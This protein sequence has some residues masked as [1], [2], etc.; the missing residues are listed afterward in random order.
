MW[1]RISYLVELAEKE[2]VDKNMNL[3]FCMSVLIKLKIELLSILV[4]FPP[5]AHTS[6]SSASANADG[7]FPRTSVVNITNVSISD[8]GNYTCIAGGVIRST[9]FVA[10]SPGKRVF[11]VG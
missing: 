7:L 3:V 8:A 6:G 5:I 2:N 1:D 11:F 4:V 10:V 9:T